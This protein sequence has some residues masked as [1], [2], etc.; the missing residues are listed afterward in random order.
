MSVSF[1]DA[2][3][4]ISGQNATGKTTVFDAF[5]WLM[6]GKDSFGRSDFDIRPL[7]A[8]GNMIHN[9]DICVECSF[10]HN[11]EDYSVRK[12]QKE[13]WVKKRGAD[14]PEFDGNQN[15]YDIDGYPKSEKEYKEFIAKIIDEA[16]FK[17]LTSPTAFTS[18]KWQEQRKILM[19]FVEEMSDAELAEKIGGFELIVP[20]LRKEP[21]ENI[22]KKYKGERSRFNDQAKELPVRIDE[23]SKQIADID[24]AETTAQ[25]A[26][27]KTDIE[28]AEGELSRTPL[29]D[30][31]LINQKI[32]LLE[33]E[34]QQLVTDANNERMVQLHELQVQ[35]D[36]LQREHRTAQAAKDTCDK[37]IERYT[38]T[39]EEQNKLFKQL[40]DKYT[41]FKT[42]VFDEKQNVCKYCGQPLPEDKQSANKKRFEDQRKRD[43][44]N[45][46][47][48][49]KKVRKNII[50]CQNS[51]DYETKTASEAQEKVDALAQKIV[52]LDAE[53]KPLRKPI[54]VSTSPQYG[55]LTRDIEQCQKDIADLDVLT[56]ERVQKSA[57]IRILRNSLAELETRMSDV[58]RNEDIRQRIGELEDEQRQVNQKLADTEQMLNLVERFIRAKLDAVSDSIN[59]MFDG[60]TFKLFDMQINGGIKE[61]C[62]VTYDGVPYSDLN[63]GH[64]VVAGLEIIR[65]LQRKF[66]V[67]VPVFV[68]NAESINDFNVPKMDCQMIMLKVTEDKELKIC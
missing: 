61:C 13:K 12:I 5:T 68:D 25:I 48:E 22:Q 47:V 39:L 44:D 56:A 3:T 21:P 67:T 19:G 58:K 11:G 49:G 18:L 16:A 64:R 65:A 32:M 60:L 37:N 20:E 38:K 30:V 26:R 4:T 66:G 17:L 57:D 7:D 35:F 33:K 51:I 36:D 40:G 14:E 50:D 23:L 2:V 46:Q 54:D 27:I 34:R 41:S 43:M 55:K 59:Q 62:E 9:I 8:S 53:I 63:T 15:L 28:L 10:S 29:P 24:E 42:L 1:S 45:V 31:G 52:A 6:F